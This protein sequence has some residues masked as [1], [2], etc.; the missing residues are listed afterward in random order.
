MRITAST[1]GSASSP[2]SSASRSPTFS[3]SLEGAAERL[4]PVPRSLRPAVGGLALG[5]ILFA[6]PELYGVGYPVLKGAIDGRYRG[7]ASS[8]SCSSEKCSRRAS[9]SRSADR[10][11]SSRR[12]CSLERRS[13]PH[14]GRRRMPWRRRSRGRPVPTGWSA[15]PP[16]LRRRPR[17]PVTAIVIVFEL[18]NDYRIIL[19]LMLA[20]LVATGLSSILS[21]DTIYTLKLRR[22]GIDLTASPPRSRMMTSRVHEAMR[23][24]PA[25]VAG[26]RRC[27]GSSPGGSPMMQNSTRC[28]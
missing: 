17:A 28:R 19:P 14:T 13:A 1:S 22:R 2:R 5:C 3:R 9:R 21:R 20:V 7:C 25:P 16:S 11:A 18:T 8:C 27:C 15:W 10:A 12:P 4:L 23:R 26:R 24:P 6:V